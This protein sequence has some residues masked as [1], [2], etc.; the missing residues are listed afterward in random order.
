MLT[1]TILKIIWKHFSGK[2]LT[3][4]TNKGALELPGFATTDAGVSYKLGYWTKIKETL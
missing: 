1:L 3:S 2:L 4:A